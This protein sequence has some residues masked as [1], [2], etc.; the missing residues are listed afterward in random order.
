MPHDRCNQTNNVYFLSSVLALV[1]RLEKAGGSEM[2]CVG[3][4]AISTEKRYKT[5]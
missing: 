5:E 2:Y 1:D 3:V 4:A